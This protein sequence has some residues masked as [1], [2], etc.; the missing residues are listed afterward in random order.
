MKMKHSA[1]VKMARKMVQGA[2]KWRFFGKGIFNTPQWNSRADG[3]AH[4]VVKK[5][6]KTQA[7]IAEKKAKNVSGTVS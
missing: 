2:P 4:R 3:I 5:L 7:R 1:K 6:A